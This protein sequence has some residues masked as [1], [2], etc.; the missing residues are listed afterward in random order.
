MFGYEF[1]PDIGRK[2]ENI[3]EFIA[4]QFQAERFNNT[5]EF[6]VANG[7]VHLRLFLC[8]PFD[9]LVLN[10]DVSALPNYTDAVVQTLDQTGK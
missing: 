10:D 1:R 8:Y 7:H 2:M 9:E 5:F 6:Q 4:I 3:S